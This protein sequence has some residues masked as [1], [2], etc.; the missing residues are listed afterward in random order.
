MSG[1]RALSAF[2]VEDGAWMIVASTIVPVETLSPFDSAMHL[3]EYPRPQIV[4]FEKV[5]EAAHRGLVGCRLATQI[6]ADKRSHRRRI[7]KR[8][9]RCRVRQIE[10]V[11]QE[12]DP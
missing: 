6:N 5:A 1:S 2:L 11:L 12:I 9:F 7:I 4:G 3:F 8:F 10:P